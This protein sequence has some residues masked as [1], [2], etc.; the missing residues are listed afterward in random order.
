ML[1]Q[2]QNDT[3]SYKMLQLVTKC[4]NQLLN[5]TTSYKHLQNVT[6]S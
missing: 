1:N 4:Y 2:L 6:T 5:V 3:T